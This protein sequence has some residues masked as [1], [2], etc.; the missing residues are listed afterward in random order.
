MYHLFTRSPPPRIWR[1]Y[2]EGYLSRPQAPRVATKSSEGKKKRLPR[3][4]VV[5][6]RRRLTAASAT[7]Q[8][9]AA[10]AT[11]Q[12]PGGALTARRTD[13]TGLDPPLS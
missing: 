9:I 3:A 1:S 12:I 7:S 8:S 10:L 4:S 6:S 5:G 11:S 13:G 2:P